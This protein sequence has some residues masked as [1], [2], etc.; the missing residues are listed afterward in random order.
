MVANQIMMINK[1]GNEKM[2]EK[3]SEELSLST[4][5]SIKSETDLLSILH[6]LFG[7][8]NGKMV[9]QIIIIHNAKEKHT[10][11]QCKN[12]TLFV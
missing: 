3:A 4:L 9:M 2:V 10:D 8:I 11:N 1:P 5:S 6:N 12:Q 7:A